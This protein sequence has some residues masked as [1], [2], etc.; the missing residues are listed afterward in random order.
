MIRCILLLLLAAV[1]I[2]THAF[3]QPVN[4]EDTL[5][6]I[7]LNKKAVDHIYNNPAEAVRLVNES[8]SL[9]KKIGY[10]NG[11]V[12]GLG[13]LGLVYAETGDIKNSIAHYAQALER[14][15]EYRLPLKEASVLN[16]L[17]L[18]YDRIGAFEKAI[19]YHTAALT[20]REQAGDSAGVAQT[21]Y[22]IGMG[23]RGKE[24]HN[25][26]DNYFGESLAIYRA[27]GNAGKVVQTLNARATNLVEGK[28]F[29]EATGLLFEAMRI[30]DTL[31]DE[32]L[33]ADIY[34]NLGLYHHETN[35]R[36]S[37]EH[38]YYRALDYYKA[39]DNRANLAVTLNN[40]G[41]L[42]LEQGNKAAAASCFE[43]SLGYAEDVSS[44]AD[45]R[46]AYNNLASVHA[47]TGDY[48]RAYGYFVKAAAARDSLINEE[49]AQTIAELHARLERQDF[50]NQK[51]A[52][53]KENEVQKL[54][55]QRKD[56]FIYAG[57]AGFSM[58]ALFG[59]LLFRQN[60]LVEKH[61]RLELEQRQLRAQMNPH[62]I[63]NCLNSIQHFI[64]QQDVRNANKYLTNFAHL[65]RQTLDN[66]EKE[67][68]G[69]RQEIEYLQS[70]LTMERMR[71]ENKFTFQL[72]HDPNLDIDNTDLPPMIVQPF[73]E[74]A[75][76]HG[77]CFLQDRDG[78]L[79]VN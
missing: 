31:E 45:M 79:S 64:V 24:F 50:E 65:M 74:N 48:R 44:L 10:K 25:E 35:R 23:F 11:E 63:F 18:V 68:I 67:T 20:I 39:T 62:F 3:A 22:N 47:E 14:S 28:K 26:A 36:D 59:T 37:A 54:R 34:C 78:T 53:Q 61:R 30:A 69:L 6:V 46:I 7:A 73:V 75:I 27:L 42:K 55:L 15:R 71:H 19:E 17:G 12:N 32:A 66:S 4:P 38:Y 41:E 16:N 29:D 51:T 57:L 60:R 33:L 70:Y 13:M 52:L 56:S 76:R 1:F 43:K 77:L 8:L 49:K 9:S 5:R 2:S 72:T 40:I 21:R 58:L